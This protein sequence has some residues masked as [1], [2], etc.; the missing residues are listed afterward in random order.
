MTLPE[1][2]AGRQ[3][4]I[5]LDL[6][7]DPHAGLVAIGTRSLGPG[8]GVTFLGMGSSP[9]VDATRNFSP[10]VLLDSE[11]RC[12]IAWEEKKNGKRGKGA[13][14]NAEAAAKAK[15]EREAVLQE[16]EDDLVLL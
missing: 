6:A 1:D 9:L 7:P 3:G 10:A 5:R 2:D 13:Q 11:E 4:P 15:A 14:R 8:A 16:E 12:R